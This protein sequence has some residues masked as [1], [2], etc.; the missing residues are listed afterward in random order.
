MPPNGGGP[1]QVDLDDW[2]APDDPVSTTGIMRLED[3]TGPSRQEIVVGVDSVETVTIR[4]S[5]SGAS[6]SVVE[7]H[8]TAPSVA[9]RLRRPS[10]ASTGSDTPVPPGKRAAV[11]AAMPMPRVRASV[12]PAPR[13][14]RVLP[15]L[16][17]MSMLGL[18]VIAVASAV[19][20]PLIYSHGD[21][22]DTLAQLGFGQAEPGAPEGGIVPPPEVVAAQVPE[23]LPEGQAAAPATADGTPAIAGIGAVPPDPSS[24]GSAPPVATAP[25]PQPPAPAPVVAAAPTPAP[26]PVPK[27]VAK[28]EPPPEPQPEAPRS[29]APPVDVSGLWIGSTS[30]A[31]SFKLTILGQT[32][33]DFE[34]TVEVQVEDGTFTSLAITGKVDG[35]G[36]ISF[37]DGA[38]QFNGKV[39]GRKV[40]GTYTLSAGATPVSW[41]AVH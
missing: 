27:A 11:M 6:A 28:P 37:R 15:L 34:G 4:S 1:Q 2:D 23:A 36:V 17:A 20:V 32:E 18:L 10:Q 16:I 40:T 30:T 3:V 26:A 12:D 5:R 41:S 24:A 21:F 29:S 35:N 31:S 8:S 33:G 19:I 9:T 14:S 22:E 38:A 25:V 7:D 13:R 39:A